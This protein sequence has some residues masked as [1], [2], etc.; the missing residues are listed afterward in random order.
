M[1]TFAS[2]HLVTLRALVDE[3]TFEA[4][5]Q[6]LHMT[7]SA[8]SQRIK[9]LE[10]TA[11]Q[12][13]VQR[14][15]PVVTTAA[16]DV[17][18]RYARQVQLLADDAAVELGAGAGGSGGTGG[19][20][21]LGT[22]IAVAVNADSLATWFL[23]ALAALPP[24]V[25]AVFDLHREDQENTTSLLRSGTVLAA[26][27]STREPLQGCSSEPLGLMRYRAVASPGFVDRWLGG[28]PT[29]GRVDAAPMLDFDRSD[30]LQRGF[31]R[32]SLGY[33]PRPPRTFVP[34]SADFARAARLGLGWGLLP[35]AQCLDLLA[36]GSLVELAPGEHVDLALYWQRW[37]LSS[38]LL[39]T[40]TESVRRS[41][42]E[43]LL[44]A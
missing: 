35:E 22:S 26:V 34:S 39:D 21:G 13:L 8:V 41:A 30:Q 27:T 31:L 2:E 14:T 5:A 40:L 4:A 25:G 33:D 6:R 44:P 19:P 7:Q 43:V 36:D 17:V 23:E 42:A 28:V 9:Q 32:A 24:E 3:G 29:M 1:I 10:R 37:A 12:V 20:G 38:R 16:G 15:T 11:G 18:L